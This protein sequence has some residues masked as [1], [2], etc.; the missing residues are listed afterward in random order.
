MVA[1]LTAM[2]WTFP[3]GIYLRS[4]RV[5]LHCS[6]RCMFC[7]RLELRARIWQ[8][9]ARDGRYP[10]CLMPVFAEGKATCRSLVQVSAF[11]VA[12]GNHGS[13]RTDSAQRCLFIYHRP[14]L[15]Y[16]P[17]TTSLPS[18]LTKLVFTAPFS[19]LPFLPHCSLSCLSQTSNCWL[20]RS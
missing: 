5:A 2:Q 8:M 17:Q 12:D 19:H 15:T 1:A 9:G 4:W 7:H 6:A 18:V 13:H 10:H 16:S 20:G 11:Y 14:H 3:M